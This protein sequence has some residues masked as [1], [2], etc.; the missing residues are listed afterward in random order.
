MVQLYQGYTTNSIVIVYHGIVIVYISWY[1]IVYQWYI[2]LIVYQW[3]TT[4]VKPIVVHSY[5][6]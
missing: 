5:A 6:I 4:H 2:Q 1:I 3:H